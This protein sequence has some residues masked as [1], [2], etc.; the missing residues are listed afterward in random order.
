[1]R[2]FLALL[3]SL[4]FAVCLFFGADET[5]DC[6]TAVHVAEQNGL[7]E[8]VAEAIPEAIAV[9]MHVLQALGL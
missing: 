5:E 4:V 2:A 7:H 3:V 1:M 6:L 9:L 8:Y